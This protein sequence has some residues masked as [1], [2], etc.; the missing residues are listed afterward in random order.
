MVTANARSARG[1]H[2][3]YAELQRMRGRTA[4]PTPSIHAWENWLQVV[5]R[6][7]L[8]SHSD[9][10]LLLS[11]WQ[12]RA[13][14]QRIVASTGGGD[15]E[16]IATLAAS[17][18]KLLSDFEGHEGRRESWRW[19][20]P[21]AES[22]RGW[23]ARFEREC[24]SNRWMS[25]SD[26]A[27][28][29]AS[30]VRISEL[31]L[32]QDLLLVGF[33]R[34]APAQQRLIDAVRVA[35]TAVV[36][37][38]D[39][40]INQQL[41][42]VQAADLHDELATCAWWARRQ[43]EANPTA[44][45]AIIVQNV[46]ALR[47]EIDRIFRAI[48]MPESIGI[49]SQD[50]MP[51]EFSLGLPLK[52]S[53][54]VKAALLLLQWTHQPLDQSS[55]SWLMTSGFFALSGEDPDEMAALDAEIRKYARLPPKTPLEAFVAHRPR[56][57]SLSANRFLSRM[58][59]LAGMPRETRSDRKET[60]PEWIDYATSLLRES[61][62]PGTRSLHSV[63]YQ[64]LQRWERLTDEL[65]AL[66]FD[67]SRV[68]YAEFVA[69]LDLYSNETVFSPESRNAPIQI[70]GALEASGQQFDAIW[71]FGVDDS[72]WPPKASPHS[73]LPQRLQRQ[74][75]I[76]HSSLELDWQFSLSVMQRRAASSSISVF[77]YAR[78]DEAE[79]LRASPLLEVAF[80]RIASTS[81]LELRA[82]LQ[83]PQEAPHRRE[84]AAVEDGSLISWPR[85]LAAGGSAI[86]K[87][88][89]ACAFQA[90]ASRR[91]G[92]EEM[93]VAERGLTPLDRG[94]ILHR[95]LEAFWAKDN[96]DDMRLETREELIHAKETGRLPGILSHHIRRVFSDRSGN[97]QLSEWM[98]SYLEVEQ[99]RLYSL[100]SR[101]LEYEMQRQ[102]F[103]VL[104]HEK[105]IQTEINGLKLNLRVDRIDQVDGGNLIIDYKTGQVSPVMWRGPR[106]D[107][108]QLPLYAVHGKVED[109]LGV[110]FAE[111]RA[112]KIG[113]CGH[114]ADS[115]VTV[116][117][118]GKRQKRPSKISL[119]DDVLGEWSD[120]LAELAD[121]FLRGDAAV[122]PKAYPKT[123]TYCA[124]GPLCRVAET[125]VV[126]EFEEGD[127]E[128]D[129]DPGDPVNDESE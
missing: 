108:P 42:V 15:S 124:L 126:L 58:R 50:A 24:K 64:A 79:E 61:G 69:M 11:P 127:Q 51:F 28:W 87:R 123:C 72:Q 37:A 47:G 59:K 128:N 73:L 33:D 70:L 8:L 46:N 55:I 112:R 104:A 10:P 60:I 20:T 90:F 22:F 96:P 106:P 66:G 97:F 26:L 19:A 81:S 98:T 65:S 41:R 113:L 121:Q 86:L 52:T 67:S 93:R 103:V 122:A 95:V 101:W 111:I 30:A 18:W 36:A 9:N 32:T 119:D 83:A 107:E 82:D 25:R 80:G 7:H 34:T 105:K 71:F 2:R 118:S 117:S 1:L 16:S 88:Q 39:T 115:A 77:S 23:A 102:P 49:E 29:L 3:A 63:E 116:T 78:R 54:L 57:G 53:P 56:T 17:A 48:L 45:I 6:H 14:W 129:V 74:A 40:S 43:I 99:G 92:A 100:L 31:K 114:V 75:A 21:D 125:P 44:S 109:L 110:L 84:T 89:S 76:P 85:E 13:V 5:W 35:G 68:G 91:L 12:E 4:W 120:V 27:G 38:P 94:D 62:W